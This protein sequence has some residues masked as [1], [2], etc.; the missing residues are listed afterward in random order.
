MPNHASPTEAVTTPAFDA[1]DDFAGPGGW[2][3]GARMV[4][5]R[6]IGVELDPVACATAV[7]AGHARIPGSVTDI[8]HSAFAGIP[9]YIASPPCTDFSTAGLG[10]GESGETGW[11]V[12]W[13]LERI[14][15]LSPRWVALEQV[16]NVLPVWRS[17]GEQMREMGYSVWSGVLNAADYGAHQDRRRAVLIGSLDIQ[18]VPPVPTHHA[19]E[20]S[21]LFGDLLP[22]PTLAEFLGLPPGWEV[23]TGQNSVLGGGKVVR[24][25][26]SCDRPAGTVT[27]KAASQWVLRRGDERRKITAIEAAGLQT[28]R[29]DYPWV[30]NTEDQ[31]RQI[32]NA[33]PPLLAAHVLSALTGRALAVAA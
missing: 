20:V 4:G 23:D 32:G 9:G 29:A 7:M 21:G 6:T 18:V 31:L 26:R 17:I 3:E 24:Y 5:L 10:R 30:G 19:S 13:P 15:A 33:V 2:D 8:A 22:H 28:F 12:R 27:T 11:L 25:V 1:L 16:A 14:K